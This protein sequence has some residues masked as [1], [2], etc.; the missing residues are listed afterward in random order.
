MELIKV[1]WPDD[2]QKRLAEALS[3]PTIQA[4]VTTHMAQVLEGERRMNESLNEDGSSLEDGI[5]PRN[6][7]SKPH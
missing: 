4:T 2:W 1:A 5:F 3:D 6:R 7:T